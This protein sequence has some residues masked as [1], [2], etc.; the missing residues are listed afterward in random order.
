MVTP[1]IKYAHMLPGETEIW[2]R[3]L[4]VTTIP[5]TRFDYDVHVGET[6]VVDPNTPDYLVPMIEAVYRKRI[7]A[8]GF[9]DHEIWLFEVKQ[10]AGLSAMG[11][12]LAYKALYVKDFRPRL[13]I[14]MGVVCELKSTDVD[15]LYSQHDI[16]VFMV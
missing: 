14:K 9:T 12:V 15:Y 10:R 11:Q 16:A 8:V 6:P 2:D 1:R 3:F 4:A 5:F 13:P 7:D